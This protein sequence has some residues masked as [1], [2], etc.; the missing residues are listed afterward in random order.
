QTQ[1]AAAAP[2]RPTDVDQRAVMSN[3]SLWLDAYARGDQRTIAT[4]TVE[5][6][7][8]RDERAGKSGVPPP[9]ITPTQGSDV[10]IARAGGAG[11]GRG[12]GGAGEVRWRG[13]GRGG[14][15]G[16]CGPAVPCS[17]GG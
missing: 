8:V 5:G 2:A 13:W 1:P 6:F 9:G 14:C 12:S 3:H 4:L 7:S 17:G 11:P 16:G 10:R 15:G